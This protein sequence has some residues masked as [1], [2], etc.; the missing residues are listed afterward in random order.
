MQLSKAY[1]LIGLI[2][3][4]SLGLLAGIYLSQR[5]SERSVKTPKL[6][7]TIFPLADITRQIAGDKFVVEQLLPTGASEHTYEPT[8][9]A[10][11]RTQDV[12][13][14]FTVGLG[15]DNWASELVDPEVKVVDFTQAV[16]LI[17]LEGEAAEE[18]GE[19]DPHYWLS[20]ANAKQIAAAIRDELISQDPANQAY[21]EANYTAYVAE[22]DSLLTETT[23]KLAPLPNKCL[24][25]FHEAF[26][27]LAAEQ[28]LEVV[29]TI[30]PYPGQ[31]PTAQYIAEVGQLIE[32]QQLKVLYKEPQLSA[33]VVSAL[34]EDYDAQVYTLDP[35]GGVPGRNSYVEL[36]RYNVNTIYA[37]NSN[38]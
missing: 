2:I 3:L 16:D 22:L 20:I 28:G 38:N 35:L 25:T 5:E 9:Q 34:A 33:K 12:I 30:E 32:Q 10:K 18:F 11:Q 8:I 24:I 19:Y 17:K 29:A 21:Y 27:Y 37:G 1:W 15:L 26:S 14:L 4:I 31:E 6:A 36:I 7:A 13:V 23:S